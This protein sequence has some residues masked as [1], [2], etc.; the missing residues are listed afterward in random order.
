MHIYVDVALMRFIPCFP[1]F[2]TSRLKRSAIV[3]FRS[4]FS[5][6]QFW[7]IYPFA[8]HVNRYLVFFSFFLPYHAKTAGTKAPAAYDLL[9]RVNYQGV[10]NLIDFCLAEKKRLVQTST[11]SVAGEMELKEG[12]D[13]RIH[14]NQLYF[15]QI[16]ENDYV[17]TK[18][19]A[20]RAVLEAK[21]ERGLDGC[22]VRMGNLM[23][24]HSDGEFQINFLTNSF[25]RSLR[26]YKSL[27]Q[28]PV[29]ALDEPVEFSPIDSS[30]EA[31]LRFAGAD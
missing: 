31:V 18:F 7:I 29:S 15:G 9:D 8:Y 22:V 14:E 17:R 26:A 30:A 5:S 27:K 4:E 6:E 21:A 19:L 16:V 24:R 12:E 11:Y 1:P 20:E 23:S 2:H 25:M 28:F 3:A 10:L 13:I